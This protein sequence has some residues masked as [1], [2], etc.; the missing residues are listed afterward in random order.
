MA[1]KA[2]SKDP[3]QKEIK[4]TGTDGASARSVS[5]RMGRQISKAFHSVEIGDLLGIRKALE[6]EVAINIQDIDGLT[7]AHVAARSDM[8]TSLKFLVGN[9]ADITITD[10][11]G[12]SVLHFSAYYGSMEMTSY[13][14]NECGL[15]PRTKDYNGKT[16][17]YYS[18]NRG[19]FRTSDMLAEKA[20]GL[21][22]AERREASGM[23]GLKR[24]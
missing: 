14:L 2:K 24:Q 12:A 5:E 18:E 11:K 7:M 16:P 9:G 8:L 3:A 23:R 21:D 20:R 17:Q 15:D 6:R 13:L 4:A 19:K 22:V 10:N 1:Y